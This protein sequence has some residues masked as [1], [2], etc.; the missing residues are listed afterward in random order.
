MASIH[1]CLNCW[2]GKRE[3]CEDFVKLQARLLSIPVDINF[4]IDEYR[5]LAFAKQCY[6]DPE[7]FGACS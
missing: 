6:L 1:H 4:R 2:K 3:T 5:G 7:I